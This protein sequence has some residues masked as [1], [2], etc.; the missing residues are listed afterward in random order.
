MRLINRA[1]MKVILTVFFLTSNAEAQCASEMNQSHRQYPKHG[2][3]RAEGG[4][5]IGSVIDFIVDLPTGRILFA[6]ITPVSTQ[7]KKTSVLLLPWSLA[8]VDSTGRIFNFRVSSHTA[9]QAPHL[10][11]KLWQQPPTMQGLTVVERYWRPKQLQLSPRDPRIPGKATA[12]IG[13]HVHGA[14][15]TVLG[16]IRELIFDPGDGAIALVVLARPIDSLE[17]NHLEF[18]SVPWKQLYVES[19]GNTLIAVAGDKILT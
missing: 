18:S 8:R 14:D 4:Q 1:V 3:A 6:V 15:N 17:D 2:I 5:T 7:E 10:S 9:R 16:T 11:A 19:R 13:V 12:L